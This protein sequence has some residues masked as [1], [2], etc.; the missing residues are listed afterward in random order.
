MAFEKSVLFIV[1]YGLYPTCVTSIAFTIH[2]RNAHGLF[3]IKCIT[4]CSDMN[5]YHFKQRF[6]YTSNI[7]LIQI[8]FKANMRFFFLSVYYLL[9]III[10]LCNRS[11]WWRFCVVTLLFVFFCRCRGF[12]HRTDS[13]LFLFLFRNYNVYVFIFQLPVKSYLH[14]CVL[15]NTTVVLNGKVRI[16][17]T[18][19]RVKGFCHMTESDL[20]LFLL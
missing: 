12:C 13:D 3:A 19:F 8:L 18:G 11:C 5:I 2:A 1:A 17:L 10:E 9:N 4:L 6:I 7:S 14:F 16:P 20:F 15:D